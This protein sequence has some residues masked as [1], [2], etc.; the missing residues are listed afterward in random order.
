MNVSFNQDFKLTIHRFGSGDM[1]FSVRRVSYSTTVPLEYTSTSKYYTGNTIPVASAQK[2]RF[3]EY[4]N[5]ICKKN[6]QK[7]KKPGVAP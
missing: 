2:K 6:K 7:K 1:P 5:Q 3:I 4:F